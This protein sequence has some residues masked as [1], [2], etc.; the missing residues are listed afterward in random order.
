MGGKLFKTERM[1]RQEYEETCVF[2]SK[3][4][5]GLNH[6]FPDSFL[7]KQDFGDIDI[8]CSSTDSVKERLNEAGCILD[9][10]GASLLINHKGKRNSS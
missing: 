2:I 8:I 5:K 4:P 1:S 3:L 10:N 7:D 9:I 6:G